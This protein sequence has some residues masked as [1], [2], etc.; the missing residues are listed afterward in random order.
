MVKEG[1]GRGQRKRGQRSCGQTE[2]DPERSPGHRGWVQ[3]SQV[4]RCQNEDKQWIR[5]VAGQPANQ[6][7]IESINEGRNVVDG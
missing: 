1:G 3:K 5:Q 7:I 2:Q 4:Q 6:G